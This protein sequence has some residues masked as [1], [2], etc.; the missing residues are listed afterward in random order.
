MRGGAA[1]RA[2]GTERGGTGFAGWI[3][4]TE[5]IRI[6]NASFPILSSLTATALLMA[7]PFS[8]AAEPD[9]DAKPPK[10]ERMD[11]PLKEVSQLIAVIRPANG[12]NVQ[13]SVVFTETGDGVEMVA[14][15]GGLNPDSEHGFH[16][17]EFG[18][19]IADDASSAGGHYNPQGHP[20]GLPDAD[21]HHAG[22]MGNLE[23]DQDGNAEKTMMLRNVTLAGK[24]NPLIG[25]G[26]IVHAQPDD[27]GQPSGNAGDRIGVGVL[28]ISAV[29]A[30]GDDEPEAE[31]AGE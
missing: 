7:A 9:A 16:I 24:K 19:A 12:S 3:A 6:M 15:I 2:G 27:G 22:D 30:G 14:K 25:R 29:S 5:T 31:E 23:A 13:G 8:F 20:H 11:H 28:G 4:Q 21:M 26:V 10:S 1:E 18:N 17:H